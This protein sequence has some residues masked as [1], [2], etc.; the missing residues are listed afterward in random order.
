[1][2]TYLDRICIMQAKEDIQRDLLLSDIQMGFVFS[3]FLWGYTLFEVPGGAM[4]DRWG[5]RRVLTCFVLWW[6]LFT[7][8]T[9]AV[10]YFNVAIGRPLWGEP[11]VFFFGDRYFAFPVLSSF[12]ALLM[13]RFFFGCGEAGAFPNAAR[14]VGNWFPF[15]ERAMAQ[16]AIWMSARLGAFIAPLAIVGLTEAFGWR[17]AFW[18]LG[19]LG[20]LWCILFAWWFRDRPEEKAS[21]NQAERDLIHSGPH[22]GAHSETTHGPMPW[23]ALLTSANVWALCLAAFCVSFGWYFYPTYQPQ[24]LKD[25][26]GFQ[27][28]DSPLLT[29]LPFLCGAIGCL[30]GGRL[31]DRLVRTTGSRRWGRSLIGVFG[32]SGAGLCFLAAGLVPYAWLAVTLLSLACF[33]NDFAIPVIWAA[34]ADIGRR[35]AGTV[36]GFMNM[37]G[38]FG[39][40]ITPILIPVLLKSLPGSQVDR[41]KGVFLVLSTVWFLGALAWLRIDASQPLVPEGPSEGEPE[42]GE[43]GSVSA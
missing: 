27:Y 39:G 24:F 36:S 31:S 37:L 23:R 41:W 1:V 10:W 17:R 12:F 3:A 40:M 20:L 21:C 33:I 8:L 11:Y 34:S 6:S 38:G 43:T 19:V 42:K 5:S 14:A 9:G 18:V 7:A 28:R 29:G 25:V 4:G 16:G 22:S 13:I 35:Y 15:R 2:L 30:L 32:F 26:H